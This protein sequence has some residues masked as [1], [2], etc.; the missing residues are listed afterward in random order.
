MTSYRIAYRGDAVLI[1]RHFT[2]RAIR[3]R[4][5]STACWT[6]PRRWRNRS[7][8]SSVEHG[9]PPSWPRCLSCTAWWRHSLPPSPPVY[10]TD[11]FNLNSSTA[12]PK[13]LWLLW[14]FTARSEL[15]KVLFLTPSVCVLLCEI[16]WEPL[17]G[18]APNSQRRRVWS[19][20]WKSLK[21]KVKGQDHQ[22]Q[23]RHFQPFRRPACGSCL[24]KHL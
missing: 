22:G 4:R 23:K 7:I 15:R 3:R 9:P 6:I 16:S 1:V 12:K 5:P 17:N 13:L 18:F 14:Y 20:A 2:L 8:H 24:V 21:V 19:V 11:T 10:T